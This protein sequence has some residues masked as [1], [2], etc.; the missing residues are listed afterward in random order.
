MNKSHKNQPPN[1]IPM[2]KTPHT[3]QPTKDPLNPSESNPI[4]PKKD[5]PN[6][7]KIHRK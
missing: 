5:D 1:E 2:K 3:H 4:N 7:E 6:P